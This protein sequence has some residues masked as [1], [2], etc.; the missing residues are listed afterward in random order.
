MLRRSPGGLATVVLAWVWLAA[1][2]ADSE[3]A[4]SR[5][6]SGRPNDSAGKAGAG[7]DDPADSPAGGT[8]NPNPN[9]GVAGNLAQAPAPV[10][11]GE[12][13][14]AISQQATNERRPA[15]IIIA[16]DNSGSMEDEIAFVRENLNAFSQQIV[17]SGVDVRIVLISAPFG[18][19]PE[20][21]GDEPF[22]FDA[23]DDMDENLGICIDPPLGSGACPADSQPPRYAHVAVEVGSHDALNLFIDTFS[24]WSDQLRPTATKT[25]VVVTDDDAEDEPNDSAA[26][27]EASVA[28]L[29]GGLFNDWRFSGI[30]CFS[31]CPDAAA[32][33]SVYAELVQARQGVGGDLCEQNFAPVFDELARAVVNASGLEC[34]WDIPAPPSG[35]QFDRQKVNVRVAGTSGAA[36]DLAQVT[37]E[38]A[39]G[40]RAGW[41]YDDAANP[42]RIL[43][44]PQSC[45][46]LQGDLDARVDVLFGCETV[47]APE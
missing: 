41:Y 1:C 34:A 8:D 11:P 29:P 31:E 21:E 9:T 22:D 4:P 7:A 40:M 38:A 20:D 5:A 25:F 17:D 35:Q 44:C 36:T 12:S 19:P 16:V 26:A 15:D 30:Y 13:C 33:G 3:P 27:F 42:T 2:S 24:Q 39:C 46:G 45:T 10:A 18:A 23:D 47:V 14:G 32:I 6:G 43:A 37:N 28:S